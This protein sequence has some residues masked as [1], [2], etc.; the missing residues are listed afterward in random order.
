MKSQNPQLL[1]QSNASVQMSEDQTEDI[2]TIRMLTFSSKQQ[3][4]DEWSQKLSM[5]VERG[6]REIMEDKERPPWESLK[7]EEK[8][9]NGNHQLSEQK[10][11]I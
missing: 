10:E 4:W 8:D 3:D 2:K 1:R 5:A 7:I 6:Y 9:N 11:M